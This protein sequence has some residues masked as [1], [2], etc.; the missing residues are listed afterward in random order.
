MP[1]RVLVHGAVWVQDKLVVHR[2]GGAADL[3]YPV[4]AFTTTSR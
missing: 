2:H 3:R 1:V 4:A